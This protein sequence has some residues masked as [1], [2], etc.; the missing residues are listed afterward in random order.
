M[1]FPPQL[2]LA[3]G[4]DLT[5]VVH[6]ARSFALRALRRRAP[7]GGH[8]PS[9]A[10][11][12]TGRAGNRP[13]PRHLRASRF[14]G[15]RGH[16]SPRTWPRTP[17]TARR[18]D[19]S[20][21]RG[22]HRW[23][24]P[25]EGTRGRDADGGGRYTLWLLV[26]RLVFYPPLTSRQPRNP[27]DIAPCEGLLTLVPNSRELSAAAPEIS[28]VFPRLAAALVFGRARRAHLLAQDRP[29]R[30]QESP[31]ARARSPPSSQGLDP[32]SPSEASRRLASASWEDL[33]PAQAVLLVF[34]SPDMAWPRH[35]ASQEPRQPVAPSSD[36]VSA[37]P[38]ERLPVPTP[39]CGV[40]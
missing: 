25:L 4:R 2:T 3:S 30:V 33:S 6:H 1:R 20:R 10:R 34:S 13:R 17:R 37:G 32:E 38:R 16:R 39:A 35:A 27:A 12:A 21:S 14:G 36:A 31:Y 40:A 18:A 24:R 28:V 22:G 7:V 9:P 8:R 29:P 19:C 26:R 5:G 15:L 11:Q 23:A